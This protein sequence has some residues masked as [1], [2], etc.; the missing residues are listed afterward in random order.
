M[1]N[2]KK[3]FVK[4][5]LTIIVIVAVLIVFKFLGMTAKYDSSY[6]NYRPM[7]SDSPIYVELMP[8]ESVESKIIPDKDMSIAGIE[9]L[10]VNIDDSSKGNIIAKLEKADTNDLVS[11]ASIAAS[12]VSSGSWVMIDMPADLVSNE[13]YVLSVTPDSSAPYFMTVPVGGWDGLP[14]SIDNDISVSIVETAT[15]VVTYGDIFYF[16]YILVAFCSLI[17]LAF[18]WAE[19]KRFIQ[20][21]RSIIAGV[22][23]IGRFAGNDIFMLLVFATVAVSIYA[24]AYLNG[25]FITADSSGYLR[26]AVNMAAG[27]GMSY[28]GIA[29]YKT[30][31]A[32]WPLMYPFLISIVM[33]L[34]GFDAYISSKILAVILVACILIIM[35]IAFKKDAWIYSLC[36]LNY[37]FM[38]LCYYTWSE[39]PFI[40][41]MILFGLSL[42]KIVSNSNPK[43]KDYVFL[44]LTALLTF[45]TRYFGIYLFF[46]GGIYILIYLYTGIFKKN[47][48]ELLKAIRLIIAEGVSGLLCVAYML[49]NKIMNGMPSGVSRTDWWD[50]YEN[51]TND[52]IGSLCAEFFN[53]FHIDMPSVFGEYSFASKAILLIVILIGVSVFVAKNYKRGAWYNSFIL[54][55]VVYY[56]MFIVIR[57]FSSMD[58]FCY[59]FFAPATFI[60]TIGI[61]GML[62]DRH[63]HFKGQ[64]WLPFAGTVVAIILILSMVSLKD[65]GYL[66]SEKNY[67]SI[68]KNVWDEAY[69]DIPQK[70]VVI[71]SDMDYRSEYY[72]PDVVNGVLGTDDTLSSLSERYYGSDY[73]CIQSEYASVMLE[74]GEYQEEINELFTNSLKDN[75]DN[76]KYLAIKLR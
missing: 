44:G 21:F 39:V 31:F 46:V 35:R 55:A 19:P 67:Y 22:G 49:V 61:M 17:V 8:G 60:L 57:Y 24:R 51:L 45:L 38:Q 37:G 40:I 11:E 72:R 62:I 36:V 16:S 4:G 15:R 48:G 27:N 59:R 34:S 74:S 52:L 26:E 30:W 47:K 43:A 12:S 50:D 3:I 18:V 10:M 7:I 63:N 76:K 29:G 69:R 28:D 6:T 14:Y 70:S 68:V 20:A 32:N 23:S 42:G 41:F 25:V 75:T 58:T 1:K 5:L 33:R 73:F 2:I 65:N 9:I 13:E 54:M 64:W 53:V 71:F 56:G 66:N